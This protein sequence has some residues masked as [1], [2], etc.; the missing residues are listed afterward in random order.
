MRNL[1]CSDLTRASSG[2]GAPEITM[3]C[4]V[5]PDNETKGDNSIPLDDIFFF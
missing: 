1:L 4:R 3:D 5:K 2:T